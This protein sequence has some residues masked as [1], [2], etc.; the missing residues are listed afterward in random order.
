VTARESRSADVR[1][2]KRLAWALRHGARELGLEPDREGWVPLAALLAALRPRLDRAQVERLAAEDP[3]GR[4]ELQG[5]RIRARYGHSFPV[6]PGAAERPPAVLYHGT[7]WRSLDTILREGLRPMRRAYVHLSATREQA[8]TV[9]AR[10][11]KPVVLRV[12]AAAAADEGIA[13]TDA[14]RGT[15]LV[16]ALPGRHLCVDE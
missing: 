8:R 10:H 1:A 3:K 5:A 6:A 16:T 2:S 13:F 7:T 15:W 14:G 9:G 4:Y 11:G 12:D